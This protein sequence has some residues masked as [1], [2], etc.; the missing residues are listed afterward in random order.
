MLF[1]KQPV[2]FSYFFAF[3]MGVWLITVGCFSS[4]LSGYVNCELK[5]RMGSW[6]M[7]W[8]AEANVA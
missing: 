5:A 8:A 7:F 4:K 6:G 3:F 2:E 1:N